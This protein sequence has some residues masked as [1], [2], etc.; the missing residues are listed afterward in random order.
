MKQAS[1][2]SKITITREYSNDSPPSDKMIPS[3]KIQLKKRKEYKTLGWLSKILCESV[4]N[5]Y[6]MDPN[7]PHTVDLAILNVG[8]INHPAIFY[9]HFSKSF[10]VIRVVVGFMQMKSAWRK[11]CCKHMNFQSFVDK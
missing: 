4:D 11:I 3:S 2:P 7:K 5:A 9:N 8:E 1:I 6:K 10:L